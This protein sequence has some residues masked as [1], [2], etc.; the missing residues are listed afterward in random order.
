MRAL[1]SPNSGEA[2]S[3]RDSRT[4]TRLS[5]P[6]QM[7]SSRAVSTVSQSSGT[8]FMRSHASASGT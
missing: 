8:T 6:R 5:S 2:R 1:F 4:L 7:P 3:T